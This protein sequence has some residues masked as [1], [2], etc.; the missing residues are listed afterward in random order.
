L[1]QGESAL[2]AGTKV[3]KDFK[4]LK[5]LKDLKVETLPL[6]VGAPSFGVAVIARRKP[7]Q[8]RK[9]KHKIRLYS[10]LLLRFAHRNDGKRS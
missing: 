1:Q 4:V 6:T 2:L 5:D 7:K 10:G 3:F 8:S 9:I